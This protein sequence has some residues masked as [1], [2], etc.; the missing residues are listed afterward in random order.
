M[1]NIF[2]SN[3]YL[4][5]SPDFFAISLRCIAKKTA[6]GL[7]FQSLFLRGKAAQNK[8]F[9]PTPSRKSIAQKKDI[10]NKENLCALCEY[11][12]ASLRE[13]F[14]VLFSTSLKKS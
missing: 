14:S 10:S 4:G 7:R 5:V 9:P 13:L 1:G 8:G 12:I 3:N 11:F 6:V 2:S